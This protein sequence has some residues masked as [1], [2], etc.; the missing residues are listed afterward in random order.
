ME[1]CA[2]T[3]NAGFVDVWI[4]SQTTFAKLNARLL[5]VSGISQKIIQSH[6]SP[7]WV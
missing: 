3:A 2:G 4:E 5:T 1:K 6:I 7:G